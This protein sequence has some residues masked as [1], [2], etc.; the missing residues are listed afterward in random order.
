MY[1][2]AACN[3]G[4]A[5]THVAEK[6]FVKMSLLCAVECSCLG[7]GDVLGVCASAVAGELLV[8]MGGGQI[9]VLNVSHTSYHPC[10][11]YN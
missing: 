5:F 10:I 9:Q 3:R 7:V 4:N 1:F 8:S 6:S 11:H 2:H